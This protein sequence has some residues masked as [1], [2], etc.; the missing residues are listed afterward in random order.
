M[1]SMLPVD[2]ETCPQ[3]GGSE[4]SSS[5]GIGPGLSRMVAT[6]AIVVLVLLLAPV[7][8]FGQVEWPPDRHVCST[9]HKEHWP[10]GQQFP[11]QPNLS[12]LPSGRVGELSRDPH[13]KSVALANRPTGKTGC[14]GCHG[15]AGLHVMDPDKGK[16]VKFPEIEPSQAQDDAFAAT[17]R[18]S[19]RCTFGGRCT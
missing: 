5:P 3:G 10:P 11:G 19:A 15:P 7:V 1:T 6:T 16:I 13:F 8:S 14:E 12:G 9:F 18:T 17:A 4:R 2:W